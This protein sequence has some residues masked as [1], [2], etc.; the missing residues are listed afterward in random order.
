MNVT[1]IVVIK[2]LSAKL[3][4]IHV[5]LDL[6]CTVANAVPQVMATFCVNVFYDSAERGANMADIAPQILANME[7]FVKKVSREK[8]SF[9]YPNVFFLFQR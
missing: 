2:D 1:A 8:R 4:L 9:I 5:H 6:V 3:I 7:E